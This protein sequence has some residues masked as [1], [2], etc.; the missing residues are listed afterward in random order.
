VL[1]AAGVGAPHLRRRIF[2]VAHTTK[3]GRKEIRSREF[4]PSSEVENAGGVERQAGT[5][6]QS[7]L[8]EMPKNRSKHDYFNG[9]GEARTENVADTKSKQNGWPK[10][11]G[12]QPDVRTSRQ[13]A[14]ASINERWVGNRDGQNDV[15]DSNGPR[16]QDVQGRPT[17]EGMDGRRASGDSSWWDVEPGVGRVA[18]G[19]PSRVDRLRCLGNA[20]VPRV[21]QKIGEMIL[22]GEK[23]L[24]QEVLNLEFK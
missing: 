2:I 23:R 6:E 8:R 9:S 15:S 4:A 10:F 5:Q 17:H 13:M 14:N 18:H 19:V 12:I 11:S 20:V 21:A 1:S 7:T 24:R 16:P 22:E 3:N